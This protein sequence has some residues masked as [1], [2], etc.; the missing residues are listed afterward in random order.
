MRRSLSLPSQMG[1]SDSCRRCPAGCSAGGV[2]SCSGGALELL[3]SRGLDRLGA[4]FELILGSDVANRAVPAYLVVLAHLLADQAACLDE[5]DGA[6]GPDALA[7]ER[8]VP[9]LE[10][11]VA[12]P[13]STARSGWRRGHPPLAGFAYGFLCPLLAGSCR[14]TR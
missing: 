11:A 13:H 8:L 3:L 12:Q 14:S 2:A 1:S 4:T 5:R 7:L 9:A 10:L 6:L